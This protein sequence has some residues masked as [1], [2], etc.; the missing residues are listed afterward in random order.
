MS[1]FLKPSCPH[2]N[3]VVAIFSKGWQDQRAS[4]KKTCPSCHA[5]V[6]LTFAGKAFGAWF[7]PILVLTFVAFYLGA[8]QVG[9]CLFASAFIAPLLA[10]L[11]L[12][13]DAA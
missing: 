10:S 11:Q 3:Q 2:C 6:K 1:S 8:D 9:A 5:A 13:K 7:L 4:T 12:E